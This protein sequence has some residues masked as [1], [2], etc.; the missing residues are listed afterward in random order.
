[1][2][3]QSDVKRYYGLDAFRCFTMTM[4][5]V[6]HAPLVFEIPDIVGENNVRKY[7]P[8]VGIILSW[9]HIWRMPTFFAIGFF[10][11]DGSF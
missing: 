5:L 2:E 1:M 9:I 4:G 8:L 11:S 7:N 6:I 10:C 3:V